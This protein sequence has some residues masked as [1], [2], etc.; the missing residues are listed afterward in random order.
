M[1]MRSD[2]SYHQMKPVSAG[3]GQLVATAYPPDPSEPPSQIQQELSTTRKRVRAAR[4]L[5][6]ACSVTL[7]SIMFA[8]MAFVISVFLSTRTEKVDGRNLWPAD[9]KTWPAYML[10][11][12]SLA[13]LAIEFFVLC[14]YWFRLDRAE[15]SWKLVLAEH[16]AHFLLWLVVTFLYRYEK[17]LKDVWGW[18]CSDIATTL[19]KDLNAPVNFDKL[20]NIQVRHLPFPLLVVRT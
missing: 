19:Q 20:C 6:R 14:F 16:L 10:L 17:E 4:M 1:T 13:T 12:A 15:R 18:S 7:N 2:Q 9:S 8:I 3:Y 11:T 5:S